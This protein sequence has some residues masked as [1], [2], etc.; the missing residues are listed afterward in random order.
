MDTIK[1]TVARYGVKHPIGIVVWKMS[2]NQFF[3]TS[4]CNSIKQVK[5]LI[6]WLPFCCCP[7]LFCFS[8][9][10]AQSYQKDS[11][12]VGYFFSDSFHDKKIRKKPL[13]Y[14]T[15]QQ[16]FNGWWQQLPDSTV[17][18]IVTLTHAAYVIRDEYINFHSEGFYKIKFDTENLEHSNSKFGKYIMKVI[19]KPFCIRLNTKGIIINEN[20]LQERSPYFDDTLSQDFKGSEWVQGT[21]KSTKM[22]LADIVS[23]MVM[24]KFLKEIN[25][26]DTVVI[27]RTDLT[28]QF[29]TVVQYLGRPKLFSKRQLI[30]QNISAYNI[31]ERQNDTIFAIT[32]SSDSLLMNFIKKIFFN[33]ETKILGD[34]FSVIMDNHQNGYFKTDV[35]NNLGWYQSEKTEITFFGTEKA[36]RKEKET[37]VIKWLN[38]K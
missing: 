25:T 36:I 20:E 7:L 21:I 34:E 15:M 32:R 1:L 9:S 2:P 4:V 31:I 27:S 22:I 29:D 16:K 8:T 3:F 26:K 19:N 17:E 10:Y 24:L 6:L 5:I 14:S 23:K 12:N 11:F 28:E 13:I 33:A 35:N 30:E 38:R 37:A 18:A